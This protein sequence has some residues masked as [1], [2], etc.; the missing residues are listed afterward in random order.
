MS[1]KN[2]DTPLDEGSRT[3]RRQFLA[4]AGA[5]TAASL[6]GCADEGGDGE[7]DGDW[8]P[9]QRMRYIIPYDEGGGTDVYARGIIEGL[10]EAMGQDIQID[11]I[12]G[13][14][15]LNGF[16]EAIRSEPDGNTFAGSAVPLEVTPQMLDDPGFDQRDLRGVGVI[17]RSTWCLVVNSEYEG[18]VETFDDVIEKHNSGEWSSIG[19]QEPGS[20]QDIITLLAKYEDETYA[21]EYDWNWEDRVQYTGTG[22]VTQAVASGEVPC[23]IG[24]DA[25]TE[26]NVSSGE[27]YPVVTFFSRGLTCTPISR[28]LPTR[29]TRKWTSLRG[30][31]VESTHRQR[32]QI[33]GLRCS[34]I[35][36]NRLSNTKAR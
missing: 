34:Q 2:N 19:I 10:T 35:G 8:E 13:G 9:S 25:G 23:G 11:N 29:D 15:G 30:L 20:P 36:S 5:G 12:P 31:R 4:V 27:V 6:A 32:R 24:T 14:G 21:P 7:D 33:N 28:P 1:N 3:S 18:E 22:P 17:G 26:P 16:G